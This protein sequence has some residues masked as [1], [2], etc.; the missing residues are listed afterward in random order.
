VVPMISASGI[1]CSRRLGGESGITCIAL[2]GFLKA[3][4]RFEVEDTPWCR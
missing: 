1:S 2:R 4:S 3:G